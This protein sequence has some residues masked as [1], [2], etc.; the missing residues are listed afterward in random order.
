MMSF[1]Q[2]IMSACNNSKKNGIY[3][4]IL[5]QIFWTYSLPQHMW[6]PH[7]KYWKTTES[8]AKIYPHYCIFLATQ[9]SSFVVKVASSLINSK[10]YTTLKQGN[11]IWRILKYSFKGSVEK[12]ISVQNSTR[13]WSLLAEQVRKNCVRIILLPF[14]FLLFPSASLFSWNFHFAITVTGYIWQ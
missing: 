6:K 11:C 12:I 4:Y 14:I 5:F 1:K 2:K 3:I 8:Y 10:K 13:S 7:T 9:I